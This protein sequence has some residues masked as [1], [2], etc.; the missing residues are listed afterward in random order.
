MGW[1]MGCRW[2]RGIRVVA[3]LPSRPPRLPPRG[4]RLLRPA[5]HPRQPSQKRQQR[6]TC[7]SSRPRPNTSFP[8]MQSA[9]GS[10]SR[11]SPRVVRE[12]E[13]VVLNGI[14]SASRYDGRMAVVELAYEDD[15]DGMGYGVQVLP[16]EESTS[17]PSKLMS[18][19]SM[20]KPKHQDSPSRDSKTDDGPSFQATPANLFPVCSVGDKATVA[21]L[22]T[23]QHYIGRVGKVN[24]RRTKSDKRIEYKVDVEGSTS[25]EK[26]ILGH[27]LIKIHP[28][29]TKIVLVGLKSNASMNGQ[30]GT[31]KNDIRDKDDKNKLR[32]QIELASN[33]KVVELAA[34]NTAAVLSEGTRVVVWDLSGDTEKKYNGRMAVITAAF[35]DPTDGMSYGVRIGDPAE[36]TASSQPTPAPTRSASPPP[37][38]PP[39]M[40]RPST[41][42]GGGAPPQSTLLLVPSNLERTLPRPLGPAYDGTQASLQRAGAQSGARPGQPPATAPGPG[43]RIPAG[44]PG[45]ILG[46]ASK[47]QLNGRTC[48]V[49]KENAHPTHG[50]V[51][52]VVVD[53]PSSALGIPL[54]NLSGTRLQVMAKNLARVYRHGDPLLLRKIE[55]RP[56]EAAR[57]HYE[58][59]PATYLRH[60]YSDSTGLSY[61]V[62]GQGDDEYAAPI[63]AKPSGIEAY[64]EPPTPIGGLVRLR[65]NIKDRADLG[66]KNARVTNHIFDP[67]EGL[68][69]RVKVLKPN[70]QLGEAVEIQENH[71]I[72]APPRKH[73][74]KAEDTVVLWNLTKPAQHHLNGRT[75]KVLKAVHDDMN[76]LMYDLQVL[77]GEDRMK[78]IILPEMHLEAFVPY[79]KKYPVGAEVLVQIHDTKPQL[80]NK[81]ARVAKHSTDGSGLTLDLSID[82][83]PDPV[84]AHPTWVREILRPGSTGYVRNMVLNSAFNNKIVKVVGRRTE[85][86]GLVYEVSLEGVGTTMA[87]GINVEKHYETASQTGPVNELRVLMLPDYDN[88][89]YNALTPGARVMMTDLKKDTHFNGQHGTVLSIDRTPEGRVFNVSPD[90]E[91]TKKLPLLKERIVMLRKVEQLLPPGGVDKLP[92]DQRYLPGMAVVLNGFRG[93][94]HLNGKQGIVKKVQ[95]DQ[96]TWYVYCDVPGEKDLC[97]VLPEQAALV[98]PTAA[99]PKDGPAQPS[100]GGMP[101]KPE[102]GCR[103]EL[104]KLTGRAHLNGK[105]GVI[106]KVLDDPRTGQAFMVMQ[107]GETK[108]IQV[109][110][111]NIKLLDP[112]TAAPPPPP[113]SK[114][115]KGA[116]VTCVHLEGTRQFFLEDKQAVIKKAKEDKQ[117]GVAVMVSLEESGAIHTLGWQHVRLKGDPM[118]PKPI[119]PSGLRLQPAHRVQV[120]QRV[121][122]VQMKETFPKDVK[123]QNLEGRLGVV[124]QILLPGVGGAD[125]DD[126]SPE[127]LKKMRFVVELEKDADMKCLTT[128]DGESNVYAKKT[129]TVTDAN[130]SAE[131]KLKPKLAPYKTTGKYKVG[132][133]V[134]VVGVPTELNGCRGAVHRAAGDLVWVDFGDPLGVHPVRT[135]NVRNEFSVELKDPDVNID[136]LFALGSDDKTVVVECP[137]QQSITEIR[138]ARL[139]RD[140]HLQINEGLPTMSTVALPTKGSKYMVYRLGRLF[141]LHGVPS[142]IPLPNASLYPNNTTVRAHGLLNHP[143][144]NNSQGFVVGTKRQ[145]ELLVAVQVDFGGTHGRMFM[146]PENVSP[147]SA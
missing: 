134:V 82:G 21:H 23:A 133:A 127:D 144:L 88:K 145:G 106:S 97:P 72:V 103:I 71:F 117:C 22:T 53:K 95:M 10:A 57:K 86:I 135:M 79:D 125:A 5:L 66:N 47:Q 111:H 92:V 73:A 18:S 107:D 98:T 14:P 67:K 62:R 40:P 32:Y 15:K 139:M 7:P 60:K 131:L 147:V 91:K 17:G 26:A 132:E 25:G 65:D 114:F 129:V 96:G 9:I 13:K 90:S 119:K 37:A 27:N 33:G 24:S 1:R 49:E 42:A 128:A 94:V 75:A 68:K 39:S 122:M 19:E 36:Q 38:A 126:V 130:L 80:A 120:G 100:S 77:E 63:E 4:L 142:N 110:L 138:S 83:V 16:R 118:P 93:R 84:A 85:N 61:F 11:T 45:V 48:V 108:P 64:K 3:Q 54:D 52:D 140:G 43:G 146:R 137:S 74:Y 41:S 50:V 78:E 121:T 99:P 55:G 70:G 76:G 124:R 143:E 141:A 8:C 105:R 46:L 6:K 12:E 44:S 34:H 59:Q 20:S 123:K 87:P 58:N 89:D 81:T 113:M 29:G 116:K 136:F 69:Y 109:G 56:T 112:A 30:K 2:N 102:V 31:V 35:P 28:S 51:Y 115:N 104:Q 101:T